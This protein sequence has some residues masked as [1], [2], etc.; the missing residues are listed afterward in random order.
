MQQSNSLR[1]SRHSG[2]GRQMEPTPSVRMQ[3][4]Q[5]HAPKASIQN[6]W[7]E[8]IAEVVVGEILS[9]ADTTQAEITAGQQNPGGSE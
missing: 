1:P 4:P 6:L 8:L 5:I 7:I 9:E 3:R 2:D